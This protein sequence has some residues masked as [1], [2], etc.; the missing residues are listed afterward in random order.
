MTPGDGKR[1]AT[2]GGAKRP[3]DLIHRSKASNPALARAAAVS[4]SIEWGVS[5]AVI[6]AAFSIALSLQGG[7][8][9]RTTR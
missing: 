9:E 3:L 5:E 1:S 4:Y 8:Y 6:Q 2:A 7:G